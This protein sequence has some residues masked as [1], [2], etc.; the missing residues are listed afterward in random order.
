M[1]AIYEA[2]GKDHY[3]VLVMLASYGT[4]VD[5]EETGKLPGLSPVW[6]QVRCIHPIT[7]WLFLW[8]KLHV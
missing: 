5:P 1:S 7:T 3:T 8:G 4:D 6:N 2:Y